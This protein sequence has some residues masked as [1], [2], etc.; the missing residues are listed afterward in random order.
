M[1]KINQ[2]CVYACYNETE[3]LYVGNGRVGRQLHCNSG[4]SHVYELNRDHFTKNN[5]KTT[6]VKTFN[7]K[8]DAVDFETLIIQ[9]CLPKYNTSVKT[10]EKKVSE[11]YGWMDLINKSKNSLDIL[12]KFI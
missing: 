12:N 10:A 6:V 3:L 1:N 4:V 9:K 11:K 2:Y 5:L 8:K 7:S